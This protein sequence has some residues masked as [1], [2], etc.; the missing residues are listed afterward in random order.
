MAGAITESPAMKPGDGESH[1]GFAGVSQTVARDASQVRDR[2]M[3]SPE[4]LFSMKVRRLYFVPRSG[5][6]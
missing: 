4:A 1:A 5:T 3:D 2:G 6:T